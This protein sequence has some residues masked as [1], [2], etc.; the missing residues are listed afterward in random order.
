MKVN[1]NF[2]AGSYNWFPQSS[3]L[4]VESQSHLT[5]IFICRLMSKIQNKVWTKLMAFSDVEKKNPKKK[6][7]K[8]IKTHDYCYKTVHHSVLLPGTYKND[9]LL[10]HYYRI[11]LKLECLQ[12]PLLLRNFLLALKTNSWLYKFSTFSFTSFA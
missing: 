7:K 9:F 5:Y 11:V 10:S 2:W 12:E 4:S 1:R 8:N 6:P 3:Y